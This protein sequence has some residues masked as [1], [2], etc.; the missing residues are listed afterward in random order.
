MSASET[1][2]N[3]YIVKV[4]DVPCVRNNSFDAILEKA[5]KFYSSFLQHRS[6]LAFRDDLGPSGAT[7]GILA[8]RNREDAL[9]CSQ[10]LSSE[11]VLPGNNRSSSFRLEGRVQLLSRVQAPAEILKTAAAE[12]KKRLQEITMWERATKSLFPQSPTLEP[13]TS[14]VPPART[15][16]IT[17]QGA[18]TLGTS[19][20]KTELLPHPPSLKRQKPLTAAHNKAI[21]AIESKIQAPT[22]PSID[23]KKINKSKEMISEGLAEAMDASTVRSS[24]VMRSELANSIVNAIVALDIDTHEFSEKIRHLQFNLRKNGE[25]RAS[26]LE[27]ATAPEALVAMRS[28]DMQTKEQAEKRKQIEEKS[29]ETSILPHGDVVFGRNIDA[30]LQLKR[31][32]QGYKEPR[33]SDA[34]TLN[35][36]NGLDKTFL[37]SPPLPAGEIIDLVAH[38]VLHGALKRTRDEHRGIDGDSDSKKAKNRPIAEFKRVKKSVKFD[39]VLINHAP[40][41]AK[42]GGLNYSSSGG[43]SFRLPRQHIDW[44]APILHADPGGWRPPPILGNQG[45]IY[46]GNLAWTNFKGDFEETVEVVGFQPNAFI[47]LPPSLDIVESITFDEMK[48][49]IEESGAKSWNLH[50]AWLVGPKM[51]GAFLESPIENS[52]ESPTTLGEFGSMDDIDNRTAANLVEDLPAQKD[53]SSLS[54][55]PE[56]KLTYKEFQQHRNN[57]GG[58]AKRDQKAKEAIKADLGKRKT[59]GRI[60]VNLNGEVLQNY[61]DGWAKGCHA[62]WELFIMKPTI[63]ACEAASALLQEGAAARKSHAFLMIAVPH[64]WGELLPL[65]ENGIRQGIARSRR[66]YISAS[67]ASTLHK[68]PKVINC[69]L[70]AHRSRLNLNEIWDSVFGAQSIRLFPKRPKTSSG[71][72]LA[73]SKPSIFLSSDVE[74]DEED[75]K[76]VA[77]FKDLL[78]YLRDS[79]HRADAL[80][81]QHD[82]PH[83]LD[84][85]VAAPPVNSSPSEEKDFLLLGCWNRKLVP[86][87]GHQAINIRD[88]RSW[89]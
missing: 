18:T 89:I 50:R 9:K 44:G 14:V 25:L 36:S 74:E 1:L 13:G 42:I 5:A 11:L 65:G 35:N 6:F 3:L 86:G 71:A 28:E 54:L 88:P 76:N 46:S 66:L 27:G 23:E 45:K 55:G 22:A 87:F 85:A 78:K 38:Q 56:R 7:W 33:Y 37:K 59:V 31:E 61:N 80:I 19:S 79:Y 24:S 15:K 57:V 84:L 40:N 69:D 51:P 60:L 47:R 72:P 62:G 63:A 68:L 70:K 77:A 52:S 32:A 64:Y 20:K 82:V 43:T 8:F 26:V 12:A 75:R 48:S 4:S 81:C 17:L 67:G 83:D 29:L 39:A 53:A 10:W 49:R 16:A 73:K 2:Q 30:A 41:P 34:D 58:P 21:V